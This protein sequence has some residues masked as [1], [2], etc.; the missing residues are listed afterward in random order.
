[1]APSDVVVPARPPVNETR[2]PHNGLPTVTPPP[3]PPSGG[4]PNGTKPEHHWSRR[5]Q[6]LAALVAAIVVLAA[7]V[8]AVVLNAGTGGDRPEAVAGSVAQTTAASPP[9]SPSASSS[10]I[11]CAAGTITGAGSTTQKNAVD[12]WVKTY[13]SACGDATVNYQVIGSAAG[14]QQ[15]VDQQVSFAGSD[16]ALKD[17]QKTAADARCVGGAATDLPMAIS[18]IAIAFNVPGVDTLRLAPATLARIFSGASISWNDPAVAAD[19]PNAALPDLPILSV[20]RSDGSGTTDRFTSFLKGASGNTWAFDS[21][22]DWKAPGGQGSKG[23]DGVTATVQSTVGAIGYVELSY[24]ENAGLST[25]QVQ[26]AAG[27]FVAVSTDGASKGASTAKIADGDDLVLTMDYTTATPD[28]YPVY[29]VTYEI[30]CTKGLPSADAALVKSFLAYT[31]STEGQ[32]AV[33][34]LGYAPL[35]TN[36]ASRVQAVIATLS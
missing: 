7:T 2:L 36:L 18:A 23:S 19:N 35:P 27:E 1:M 22:S 25:A 11:Q 14:R 30:T 6:V 29:V 16:S 8:T 3:G 31:A 4:Y 13:Q 10:G 32:D 9:A 5:P 20:H 17:D 26:N 34:D 15:F 24:A 12:E 28:A 33:S 21:G